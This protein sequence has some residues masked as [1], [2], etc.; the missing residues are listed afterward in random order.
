MASRSNFAACGLL[1][2][3]LTLSSPSQTTLSMGFS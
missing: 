3:K 2:V 1:L